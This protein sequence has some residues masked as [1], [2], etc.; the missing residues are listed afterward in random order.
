MSSVK[1]LIN[2]CLG[3]IRS[4]FGIWLFPVGAVVIQ[5]VFVYC[6]ANGILPD[7]FYPMGRFYLLLLLAFLFAL[8]RSGPQGIVD[9]IKPMLVWRV[10]I[11]WYLFAIFWLAF[12]ALG[13]LFIK[14][15]IDGD[16]FKTIPLTFNIF[17]NYLLIK[18]IVLNSIIEEI[19][20]VGLI[21]IML[22]KKFSI[23]MASQILAIFW[24]LWWVPVILYGEAVIPGL[25]LSI[26]WFHYLGIAATC[27]WVY[28]FTK[29]GL[30]VALMQM[31]TNGVSLIVP[32]LP[33]LSDMNTYIA[34][35]IGKF[36][37]GILLFVVFGPKPLFR[38]RHTASDPA[39]I[40]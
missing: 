8:L 28:Y 34:F 21:L 40:R 7:R 18:G 5:A 1:R 26:L 4:D 24:Y 2:G 39:V 15:L 22:Q 12:F 20:W 30:V 27:A 10:S 16:P 29:S 35:I 31:L 23:L 17:N 25:P 14:N 37:F 6:I 9:I 19:V 13:I 32:I 33:H 3:I 11:G 36:V 38:K